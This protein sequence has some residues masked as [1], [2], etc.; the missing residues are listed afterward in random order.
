MIDCILQ[1]SPILCRFQSREG[2]I[3]RPKGNEILST[4]KIS[5]N[6]PIPQSSQTPRINI[7]SSLLLSKI[8]TKTN[9]PHLSTLKPHP[10]S[11]AR[12]TKHQD[13]K[14]GRSK[15]QKKNSSPPTK[16]TPQPKTVHAR[17]RAR[18][19]SPAHKSLRGAPIEPALGP[20]AAPP[21]ERVARGGSRKIA[22]KSAAFFQGL[23]RL[24]RVLLCAVTTRV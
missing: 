12:N 16:G 9:G 24:A 5:T 2:S 17:L 18:V 21:L 6:F 8:T 19:I 15:K 23:S 1:N 20:F 4:R 3:N 11:T 7:R 14:T 10:R 22:D 13:F